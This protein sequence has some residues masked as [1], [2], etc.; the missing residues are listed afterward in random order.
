MCHNRSSPVIAWLVAIGCFALGLATVIAS[1]GCSR[2]PTI[3][4]GANAA[5]ARLKLMKE[6]GRA[7]AVRKITER[8]SRGAPLKSYPR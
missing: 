8:H 3:S 2:G 6:K 5:P 1:P 4:T 7:Y